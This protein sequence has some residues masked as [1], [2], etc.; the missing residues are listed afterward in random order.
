MGFT[1]I[2]GQK[3]AIELLKTGFQ[4]ERVSHAYLFYGPEG[5]GKLKT[6]L[7]FTQL[8]NCERPKEA[9]PC[10]SCIQCQKIA[11]GN[12]PDIKVIVPDGGSLKIEQIRSLQE[13]VYYRCYEGKKK[14]IMINHAHLLTIE[15]A[16]SLLKV[17]EEPPAETMF[18]LLVE[19]PNKLPITIQSRCQPIPFAHLTEAG[20][21]PPSLVSVLTP[22]EEAKL[23]QLFA[24]LKEGGYKE[25]LSWAELIDKSKD[26]NKEKEKEKS[27]GE[28]TLEWLRMLYRDRLIWLTTAE[29]EL[30]LGLGS[31]LEQGTSLGLGTDGAE[32]G[33]APGSVSRADIEGCFKA[34]ELINK[35]E[36]ALKNKSN[37]RLTMEVLFIN[38]K[39]IEQKERGLNPNG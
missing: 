38:L 30:L 25:A 2:Q 23:E 36:Y 4:A 18:I 19:D 31:G 20:N 13:K 7:L 37:C 35:A 29:E 9:E 22:A 5:A 3:R 16:N 34:L 14:V 39:K 6:A 33:T 28:I 24:E 27:W 10:G 32:E 11:T 8:L 17:L 21:P 1:K 15:A 12:H 26:K